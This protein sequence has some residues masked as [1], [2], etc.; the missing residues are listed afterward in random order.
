MVSP[1]LGVKEEMEALAIN[2]TASQALMATIRAQAVEGGNLQALIATLAQRHGVRRFKS[3]DPGSCRCR[4]GTGSCN[5]CERVPIHKDL[6]RV[7]GKDGRDGRSGQ[8]VTTPLYPG[9]M[10]VA[11][12]GTFHVRNHGRPDQEYTSLYQLELLDFDVEDENGDGIFEPGEHLFIRRIRIQNTGG[13]PS[14]KRPI[15]VS[16]IG[17]EWFLP[18]SGNEGLAIIP[19]SIM[20]GDS[21]TLEGFIKGL[22]RPFNGPQSP[23]QQFFRSEPVSVQATLPWL[24]RTLPHFEYFRWVDVQFLIELRSFHI[25]PA[26]AQGSVNHFSYEVLNKGSRALGASSGSGRH[27]ETLVTLPP[28][29]GSLLSTVDTWESQA[30][31]PIAILPAEQAAKKNQTLQVAIASRNYHSITIHVS[32]YLSLPNNRVAANES[33]EIQMNLIQHH[34]LQVQVSSHHV[35]NAGSSFLLITNSKITRDR[36]HNIRTLITEELNMQMDEWNVS[37]YGGLQYRP[38][39]PEATPAY[40]MQSYRGR[41]IIFMGN[42]FEFFRAGARSAC[43]FCDPQILAELGIH[44]TRFLFL[45]NSHPHQFKILASAMLLP[46]PHRTENIVEQQIAS[47]NFETHTGMLESIEQH[48]IVGGAPEAV[49]YTLSPIPRWYHLSKDAWLKGEAKELSRVLRQRLPQERF[50]LT[51][52][53]HQEPPKTQNRIVVLH[54]LPQASSILASEPRPTIPQLDPL[55]RFMVIDSL[56]DAT[57]IDMLWRPA[58]DAPPSWPSILK[59]V[60][61]SLLLGINSD[62]RNFLHKAAWPNVI[63]ITADSAFLGIHLPLLGQLLQHPVAQN[64]GPLPGHVLILL[65]G[66]LASCQPQRKRQIIHEIVLPFSHRRSQLHQALRT[67]VNGLLVRKGS[68]MKE[69]HDQTS[70]LDSDLRRDQRRDTGKSIRRLLAEFT[71]CSDHTFEHARLQARDIVPRTEYCSQKEWD[72]RWEASNTE[73]ERIKEETSGAWEILEKMV[74]K[75]DAALEAELESR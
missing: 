66:T 68:C 67:I 15:T 41:T 12:K 36:V 4:G 19:S 46:V 2:A 40:V 10:G 58:A 1:V 28:E 73:K 52:L 50:L 69:L 57:K 60:T 51:S 3:T 33:P 39:S 7:P 17:S 43:Q 59:A 13:M 61:L 6:Q 44:G 27:V 38:D 21:K 70:T 34:K 62:M 11:G 29:C 47:R 37:L 26:M 65:D 75:S 74:V 23:G 5:G 49:V 18:V 30:D 22:I 71:K 48:K 24:N 55:E 16:V 63:A 14:P 42:Q 31:Y 53:R 32:L 64:P 72:R 54:R 56:P 8:S 20:P 35:Y 9:L 25:L 45:E